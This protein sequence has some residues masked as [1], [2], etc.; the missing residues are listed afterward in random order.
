MSNEAK[1]GLI[2]ARAY[3]RKIAS[4]ETE[5]IVIC[6]KREKGTQHRARNS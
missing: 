5:G 6:A 4:N 2:W 1:N 3:K